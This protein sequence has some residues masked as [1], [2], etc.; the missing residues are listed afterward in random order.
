MLKPRTQCM[1][2]VVKALSEKH[3]EKGSERK[4][5]SVLEFI[6]RALSRNRCWANC[7]NLKG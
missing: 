3:G 2:L 5:L 4:A 7:V 6:T 1:W